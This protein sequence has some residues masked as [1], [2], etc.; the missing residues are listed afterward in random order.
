MAIPQSRPLECGEFE[1][2]CSRP[3]APN[4]KAPYSCSRNACPYSQWG[5]SS[6]AHVRA[7]RLDAHPQGSGHLQ[8]CPLTHP[9][10]CCPG[11]NKQ[12]SKCQLLIHPS[13]KCRLLGRQ[14]EPHPSSRVT[15][16]FQSLDQHCGPCSACLPYDGFPGM[17]PHQEGP[18][19][20][21][22][23]LGPSWLLPESRG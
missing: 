3:P 4:S 12:P 23:V 13:P 8:A 5:L 11:Q 14:L 6:W 18:A 10:P 21:G 7:R 19:R 15:A 1:P 20:S 2:P 16:V 9:I 17:G 22:R